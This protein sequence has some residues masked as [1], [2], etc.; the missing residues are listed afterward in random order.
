MKRSLSLVACTS[1]FALT[2]LSGCKSR[3]EKYADDVCDCKDI[4]CLQEVGKKHQDLAE[5]AGS[6]E[7]A[8]KKLDSLSDKDKAAITR[9]M[10][11]ATKTALGALGG[12]GQDGGSPLGSQ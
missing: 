11:C 7:D 12:I 10:G 2:F 6:A 4:A 3:F 8:M 5:K 1:V 9:A